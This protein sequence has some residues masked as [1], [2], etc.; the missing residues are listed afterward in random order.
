MTDHR[1]A[2]QNT[3]QEKPAKT[4]LSVRKTTFPVLWEANG[5]IL[6]KHLPQRE[7]ITAAH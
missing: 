7:A 1:M 3:A 2:S 6:A 5:C 4:I